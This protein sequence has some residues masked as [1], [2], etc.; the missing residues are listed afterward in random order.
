LKRQYLLCAALLLGCSAMLAS[1]GE[2]CVSAF[3]RSPRHSILCWWMTMPQRPFATDRRS[4]AARQSPDP[5]SPARLAIEWKVSEGRQRIRFKLRQ[6]LRYSDGTPFSAADVVYTMQQLMDQSCT[7]LPGTRS[8]RA[9][10][11]GAHAVSPT[12]V[13]STF[14]LPWPTWSIFSIQWQLSPRR[15]LRKRWRF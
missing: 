13:G 11:G 8:V 1:R 12:I 4:L 3:A 2:S 5:E 6:G 15:R 7:R 14:L 10:Q 9:K